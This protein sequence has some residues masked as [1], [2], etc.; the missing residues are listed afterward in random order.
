MSQLSVNTPLQKSHSSIPG[1]ITSLWT[2]NGPRAFYRGSI[3]ALIGI[4]PYAGVDL[5]VFETLK[6]SYKKS[7]EG[8]RHIPTQWI[9]TF[10]MSSGACGAIMM[11]PLSLI[12]TRMQAQGTPSH[13]AHYKSTYDAVAKTYLREGVRGFYKGL[14]PT[15]AKVLPAISLSYV[16]YEH[17]KRAMHI[18]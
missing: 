17:S 5:M 9:I 2:E 10:G 7:H 12:R 1:I 4:I 16:V 13:P 3:P 15:L 11:Y 14:A 18:P 8:T 6:E